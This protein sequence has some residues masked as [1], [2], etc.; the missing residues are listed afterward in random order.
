MP[1]RSPPSRPHST[2]RLSQQGERRLRG[3]VAERRAG[4]VNH[5]SSGSVPA[6]GQAQR[7][8]EVGAQR[9]HLDVRVFLAQR[10]GRAA[11]VLTRDVD[12]H[13][14]G[15]VAQPV[16]EV[17]GLEAAAAAILDEKATW[18]QQPGHLRPVALHDAKLGTRRVI[19]L[20][21]RDLLEQGRAGLVVEVLARQFFLRG[22]PTAQH[23]GT[24]LPRG[25]LEDIGTRQ[26]R[27]G[28]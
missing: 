21:L 18:P 27:D 11:Q 12:G 25:S 4:E 20:Q 9:Q 14:T 13:V 6:R 7:P 24:E 26:M 3:E 5:P 16:E 17:P 1:S 28:V 2:C 19:L 10:P 22:G 23:V 8:R 15:R